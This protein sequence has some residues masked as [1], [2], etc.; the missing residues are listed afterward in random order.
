MTTL[1][2]DAITIPTDQRETNPAQVARLV[3]KM[4]REG[5]NP[6]YP[7]TVVRQDGRVILVDGGHR[8]AA[9]RQ[10]GIVEVPYLELPDGISRIRHS[11]RCN[12][13]GADTR[14][15]DVFDYASRIAALSRAGWTGQQ[16]AEE[17]GWGSAAKVTYYSNVRALLHP[18]AWVTA[19]S[20]LTR[21]AGDVN[22]EDEGPVNHELTNV[23]WSE[24]HFRA[25]L[26]HIPC[27]NGDRAM[28]RAQVGTIRELMGR[29]AFTAKVVSEVAQRYAW[30]TALAKMMTATLAPEVGAS[31]R[32]KLL[33][34]VR[35]NVYGK[36]ENDRDQQR[37]IETLAALNE[38]ALGV[39]LYQDDALQR[40]PLLPDG[41]VALVVADPPYNVTDHAW[42]QIGPDYLGWLH[43]WLTALQP[44][45][46]GEYHL[47][48]FCDPD[49]A[50]PIEMM[51]RAGGWPIKSRIIWEYRN[52]VNGRDVTDKFIENW[53][54]CFHCGNHAL[55]WPPQWDDSRFMVQHHATPQSNFT[56]GKNHPTAKPLDLYKLLVNVGSKPGDMVLDPF[57]GGG[58]TGR[59]CAAIGQRRCVLIEREDEYCLEIEKVLGIRRQEP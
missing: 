3:D 15:D 9:A 48:V 2:V 30:H 8:I 55:N 28:M 58:T 46:A 11:I 12:A 13:D 18:R 31:E 35:K 39:K 16:I 40:I 14:P 49:Y 20:G 42:D 26:A 22:A 33:R 44:K 29:G 45:L 54:M 27:P 41:A 24:S 10:V 6:S 21:I 38:R 4:R 34:N 7:I 53:Q 1:T 43:E 47:F 56:E 19:K 50:A 52:L 5:F 51:L 57:A 17:L 59:A 36:A 32:V 23:N 37:F 25:L